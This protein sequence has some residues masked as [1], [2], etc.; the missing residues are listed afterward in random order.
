[1]RCFVALF[2][3][4]AATL[5]FSQTTSENIVQQ[6]INN[7]VD[8]Y[9]TTVVE[10]AY[11]FSGQEYYHNTGKLLGHPFC[12]VE[13][14]LTGNLWYANKLYNNVP[15]KLDL[16]HKELI[17]HSTNTNIQI[18]IQQEKID[19]FT[20]GNMLFWRLMPDSLNKKLI[21]DF[22]EV[23]HKASL[24]VIARRSKN[25]RETVSNSGVEKKIEQQNEFYILQNGV[26]KEI[27]NRNSFLDFLGDRKS[28]VAAEMSKRD[29]SF[30]STTEKYI[31][32]AVKYYEQII[33]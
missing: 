20:L 3:V 24:T 27:K 1:M 29:I 14:F 5:G 4:L 26:Y 22:Y 32:E 28:S 10:K 9:R 33:N 2:F 13:T 30:N 8:A 16:L 11:I 25:I 23:L 6:Q 21:P 17:T 31:V 12:M 19:S 7:S 15:L 18:I